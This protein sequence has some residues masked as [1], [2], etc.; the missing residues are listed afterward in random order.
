MG[1]KKKDNGNVLKIL[2]LGCFFFLSG[3]A[4][5]SVRWKPFIGCDTT[6][7]S[8]RTLLGELKQSPESVRTESH[9]EMYMWARRVTINV[10]DILSGQPL[11][12]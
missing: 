9:R 10:T 1:D 5:I 8:F 7:R 2:T 4:H 11:G 6:E 3:E 12:D